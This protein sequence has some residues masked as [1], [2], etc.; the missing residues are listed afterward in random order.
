M[1]KIKGIW[2]EDQINMVAQACQ[3]CFSANFHPPYL[4]WKRGLHQIPLLQ[5]TG[6]G[7]RRATFTQIIIFKSA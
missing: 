7:E 6:G 2:T 4:S 3:G 1:P 5:R